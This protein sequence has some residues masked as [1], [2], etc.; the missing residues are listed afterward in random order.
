MTKGPIIQSN[1]VLFLRARVLTAGGRDPD[2]EHAEVERQRWICQQAAA[3]LGATIVREYVEF[4]GTAPLAYRPALQRM[5]AD[6]DT[7]LAVRYVLV[8]GID[9]LARQ[10]EDL[11]EL[12]RQIRA[13]GAVLRDTSAPPFAI[14]A[15]NPDEAHLGLSFPID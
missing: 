8:T 3:Q 15:C 9:R 14:Y 4:G 7:L 5:L 11:R 6:L 13:A 1:A 2:A 10:P 12:Q